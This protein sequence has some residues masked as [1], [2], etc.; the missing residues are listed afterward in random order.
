[1]ADTPIIDPEVVDGG[2]P[3]QSTMSVKAPPAVTAT[4]ATTFRSPFFWMV[5]GALGVIGYYEWVRYNEGKKRKGF[6]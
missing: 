2:R 3:A 1:M 5:V 6:L 4:W